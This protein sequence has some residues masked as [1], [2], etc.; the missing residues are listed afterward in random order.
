MSCTYH[1][2]LQIETG[3]FEFRD[4]KLERLA[5]LTPADRKWMD[6][7]VNDVNDVW[8]ED[9]PDGSPSIQYGLPSSC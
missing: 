6:E 9:D 8:N 4:P 2:S 7:V 3:A 1:K 5:G